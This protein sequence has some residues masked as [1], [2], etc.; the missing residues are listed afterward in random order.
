[1][2]KKNIIIGVIILIACCC[3]SFTFVS[4]LYIFNKSRTINKTDQPN[5]I[6]TAQSPSSPSSPSSTEE[7]SSSQT[8]TSEEKPKENTAKI[9]SVMNDG[10]TT[11]TNICAGKSGKPWTNDIPMSWNG[12]DCDSTGGAIRCNDYPAGKPVQC[13]CVANGKGW[14]TG[15]TPPPL[16]I[17]TTKNEGLVSCDEYCQGSKGKPSRFELPANW[18]GAK[19]VGTEFASVG[20]DVIANTAIKCNCEMTGTGW[21]K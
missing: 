6:D 10:S 15:S 16:R 9:I 12:A 5:V 17:M 8:S 18:N 4:A 21:R 3:C 1:M 7:K 13:N 19:C 14:Y 11:C 2:E 20:C